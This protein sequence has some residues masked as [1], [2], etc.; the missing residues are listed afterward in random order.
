MSASVPI[1][2]LKYLSLGDYNVAEEIRS[3]YIIGQK[4]C[5]YKLFSTHFKSDSSWSLKWK[6]RQT[7]RTKERKKNFK[8][9]SSI[10]LKKIFGEFNFTG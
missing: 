8:E 6:D 1:T 7:E 4:V 2:E 9:V 10:S 5:T 3:R